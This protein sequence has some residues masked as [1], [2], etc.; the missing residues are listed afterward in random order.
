MK[1]I[2]VLIFSTTVL[3]GCQNQPPADVALSNTNET[4]TVSSHSGETLPTPVPKSET[5][6]KWTQSGNPIDTKE[7]DAA[8]AAAE[9]TQKAKPN[10]EA[11]KKSLAVAFLKRG[12]ALT[13]A[14]QYASAL[15]DYR[16][17]LKSDPANEEAK[18]WI[19]RIISI[20]DSIN[21]E[22]PPEGEEPPP[23]PF[24]DKKETGNSGG[25]KRIEFK[26]GAISAEAKGNLNGYDDKKEFV[27]KVNAG[28]TLA[29]EQIKAD[30]SLEYVTVAVTDPNGK[31]V[32]D[33]DASCNN[34]REIAPTAAGDYKIEVVECTKADEW[35]GSFDLKVSVK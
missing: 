21:R 15:G 20:Y 26:S 19:D 9:K 32:G 4:L 24:G 31:P 2:A 27:I 35:K 33:S 22:Y 1:G 10:D 5:K 25:A 30:D 34:R 18:K 12:I 29:T 28:Q 17:A 8:I 3:F 23:L 11:A 6:T 13:E 7:F 16:R 14:R